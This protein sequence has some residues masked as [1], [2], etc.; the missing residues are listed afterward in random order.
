MQVTDP[1]SS[2]IYERL[3]LVSKDLRVKVIQVIKQSLIKIDDLFSQP[4]EIN[5]VEAKLSKYLDYD[6]ESARKAIVRNSP[7]A[8]DLL[9]VVCEVLAELDMRTGVSLEK[10]TEEY[11]AYVVGNRSPG[12]FSSGEPA[13]VIT[14][15]FPFI[16]V[17]LETVPP[18]SADLFYNAKSQGISAIVRNLDI[19]RSEFLGRAKEILQQAALTR[20]SRVI[21]YVD[22]RSGV[23]KSVALDRLCVEALQIGWLVYQCDAAMVDGNLFFTRI[24]EITSR[25]KQPVLLVVDEAHNLQRKGVDL[26]AVDRIPTTQNGVPLAIFLSTDWQV[27]GGS[28]PLKMKLADRTNRLS[29]V[30]ALSKVEAGALVRRIMQ[31]EASGEIADVKCTLPAEERLGLLSDARDRVMAIALLKL[32]Y[33]MNIS[34]I[35]LSEYA[36]LPNNKAQSLYT[37]IA[38]MEN[39]GV[40]LELSFVEARYGEDPATA[41]SLRAITAIDHGLVRV[42]HPILVN[43]T[44]MVLLP[45]PE[46]RLS[47]LSEFFLKLDKNDIQERRY[48]R[49][50]L[51]AEGIARKIRTLVGPNSSA[52]TNW[53][54]YLPQLTENM[55]AANLGGEFHCFMGMLH[56]TI[57]RDDVA[58]LADFQKAFEIDAEN[59]FAARQIG[60]CLLR[61]GRTQEAEDH[62]TDLLRSFEFDA[63]TCSDSAFI[64][65]WCSPRGFDTATAAYTKLFADHEIDDTLA[66]R[67]E[68]HK[69]AAF[70]RDTIADEHF[71][72]WALE[73]M[74]AP[75]FVWR[76]RNNAVKLY[77]RAVFGGL[78]SGLKSAAAPEENYDA[79]AEAVDS[80]DVR[81]KALAKA[82]LARFW[83]ERWY[84]F[85]EVVDFDEIERWFDEASKAYKD[86]PF[87]HCWYGTFLKEAR[88]DYKRAH[89]MYE[90]SRTLAKGSKKAELV[91]HPMILNNL[92]LLYID[93]VYQQKEQPE[94]AIRKAHG[95]IK[96]AVAKLDS[97]PT[98][99]FNW[100][101]DTYAKIK[102]TATEFGVDID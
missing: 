12:S 49:R 3:S 99:R 6:A 26:D 80:K 13:G 45:T 79:A 47:R 87:L 21:H 92:A 7:K 74:Q 52:V 102:M 9:P 89:D 11:L 25:S 82:T 30:N 16:R 4:H 42:R 96:I 75:S 101:Y 94:V 84:R 32:R 93:S 73:S 51:G 67:I 48:L 61:L 57:K 55:K 86:E 85:G 38:L 98:L 10:K 81:L 37:Q 69:E 66:R 83:Y 35:I 59:S 62:C 22:G 36:S 54:D 1:D 2:T 39:L 50:F 65:S 43:R 76:A 77:N 58:A 24:N 20:G 14:S 31:A 5:P 100:P 64:L 91:E 71:P 88:Q 90:L 95:L 97:D 63:K 19:E 72:D 29:T 18:A 44:V 56:S 60:W 34:E 17:S 46:E 78:M 41:T 8:R 15:E 40:P 27:S 53:L 33:G 68:K 28:H 23:G 70:V